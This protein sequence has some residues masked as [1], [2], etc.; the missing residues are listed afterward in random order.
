MTQE[1][2]NTLLRI[3]EKHTHLMMSIALLP[4]QQQPT[5]E[6]PKLRLVKKDEEKNNDAN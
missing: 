5:Q 6:K 2:I 4:R 1:Q 3:L